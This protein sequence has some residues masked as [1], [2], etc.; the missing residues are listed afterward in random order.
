MDHQPA[1]APGLA[2]GFVQ[3]RVALAYVDID[4]AP[5]QIGLEYRVPKASQDARPLSGGRGSLRFRTFT[6]GSRA[7]AFFGIRQ[8]VLEE[9]QFFVGIRTCN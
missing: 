8:E 3:G 7:R 2:K 5:R 9:A 1:G 4:P 6:S